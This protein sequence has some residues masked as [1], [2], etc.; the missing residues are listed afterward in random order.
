MS[1]IGAHLPK[2]TRSFRPFLPTPDSAEKP[3]RSPHYAHDGNLP[4]QF[5]SLGFVAVHFPNPPS[6]NQ[7]KRQKGTLRIKT[8]NKKNNCSKK[9][10]EERIAY[11]KKRA[12]ECMTALE[13]T[14][15]T[16]FGS[17]AL[18]FSVRFLIFSREARILEALHCALKGFRA[19]A[20]SVA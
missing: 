11:N 2:Y 19:G 8:N 6:E 3:R 5:S 13:A 20:A 4:H 1:Y 12:K 14:M 7:R 9:K 10:I 18:S 15:T 16:D 17:K